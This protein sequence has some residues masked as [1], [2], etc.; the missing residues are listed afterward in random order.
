MEEDEEIVLEKIEHLGNKLPIEKKLNI[1]ASNDYFSKKKEKYRDS[2]IQIV[3]NMRNA[4]YKKWNIKKID[5]R[6]KELAT[7]IIEILNEWGSNYKNPSK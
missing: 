1:K 2:N 6:D 7:Q 4:N 5:S 3:K